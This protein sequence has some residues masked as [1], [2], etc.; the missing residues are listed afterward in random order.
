MKIHSAIKLLIIIF[1]VSLVIPVFSQSSDKNYVLQT[2]LLIKKKFPTTVQSLPD[3]EKID[4]IQYFDGL[5]RG[6][7]TVSY[8]ASPSS[9]DL[10]LHVEYDTLGRQTMDFLPFPSSSDGSFINNGKSGTL[11]YYNSPLDHTIPGTAYPYGERSLD[12]SPLNR[13]NKQGFPGESWQLDEHPQEFHYLT[14]QESLAIPVF[15]VND[16]TLQ[17]S[18]NSV[19]PSQ[20]LY[21]NTSVDED[22]N[23]SY[24]YT[25]KSGRTL[26]VEK[27]LSGTKLRTYYLYDKYSNLAVVISPEGSSRISGSF[28]STSDFIKK[29]CYTYKYDN[30]NRVTEKQLPGMD[31]P[32]YTVY[33]SLDHVVLTQDGNMRASDQWYFT[34]YDALGRPIM[35]GLYYNSEVTSLQLI[36]NMVNN[37]AS[38]NGYYESRTSDN[39][40]TQ[41]GYTNNAFPLISQTTVLKVYHYDDYNFDSYGTSD[42]SYAPYTLFG[43]LEYYDTPKGLLTGSKVRVPDSISTKPFM[44]TINFYD[45]KS[46]IIQQ[47]SRNHFNYFDTTTTKYNFAGDVLQNHIVHK[48]IGGLTQITDSLVYDHMRRLKETYLKINDQEQIL[49]SSMT[50]NELGQLIEK[51]LHKGEEGEYL[52]SVDYSYSIRGWLNGINQRSN[53]NDNSDVFSQAL[54]YDSTFSVLGSSPAFNG[55][56]SANRWQHFAQLEKG[57]GYDYDANS[58]LISAA[59]G[60]KNSGS[61]T[62]NDNYSVPLVDY[63]KNGNIVDLHRRGYCGTQ[64]EMMDSLEYFYE[65]NRIVGVNDNSNGSYGFKDNGNVYPTGGTEYGYDAN[66]NMTSDVNKG[67]EEVVYNHLNLP[68]KIEFE[69]NRRIHYFYDANGIKLRKEYY[70]DNRLVERT[71]Y[72]GMFIYTDDHID[73]ILT[74]EGRLKVSEYTSEFIPEYFIKDHLGNVRAVV[75]SEPEARF[76]LQYN[77]YYPFGHEFVDWGSHDNQIKYNGKELQT[78]A[79]LTWYDYGARFYDPVIG[80]WHVVDRFTEKYPKLSPYQY[81]ANNPILFIDVNGDSIT[82]PNNIVLNNKKIIQNIRV[83]NHQVGLRT[84]LE[85]SEFVIQITGGDR[86]KKENDQGDEK[87]YSMSNDREIT[88]SAKKS[89]H[90]ITE[91]ARAVDL[92]ITI[93]GRGKVNNE[94]IDQIAKDLGFTYTKMDYADGHIHLQLSESGSQKDLTI[95]DKNIPS[96]SELNKPLSKADKILSAKADEKV[97][98]RFI[99]NH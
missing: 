41:H 70:E 42:Y 24:S 90:L 30:R 95:D 84:K 8:H 62:V 26:C 17:F 43:D 2:D 4:V 68:E 54:Y 57:Y 33:D 18:T 51:N 44:L 20:S 22:G 87:I 31:E 86:Y 45:K 93:S 82:N 76:P 55:N 73:Y 9:N 28:S 53:G 96:D 61:W 97:W 32:I 50:Y 48:D 3:G 6:I 89:R 49:V 72:S 35:E 58:R 7:Q 66:G 19:Y 67:I 60:E 37:H 88:N 23:I 47:I 79:D 21:F 77:D 56:I 94:L 5:G 13:I 78:E 75:S 15:E 83:L 29:W 11:T 14:Y 16:Q 25:D 65:G 10:V 64:Y 59:Y 46:R 74:S 40:S 39:Y 80:R 34:K 63:D 52:Q 1:G 92:D 98:E 69:N 91:G 85:N 27:N 38:Q 81:S 71:D 12:D 36:Q 99:E